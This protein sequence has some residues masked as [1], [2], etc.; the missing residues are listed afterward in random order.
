MKCKDLLEY[1]QVRKIAFVRWRFK[2]CLYMYRH[3]RTHMNLTLTNAEHV[4]M[5]TTL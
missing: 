1:L 2:L 4:E 5:P 3:L